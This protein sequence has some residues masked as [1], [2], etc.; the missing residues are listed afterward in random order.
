MDDEQETKYRVEL[1]F[2]SKDDNEANVA[3]NDAQ[4]EAPT[5]CSEEPTLRRSSREKR[6]PEYYGIRVNVA[7]QMP[8]EPLTVEDAFASSDWEK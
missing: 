6:L 7:D 5:D 1:D 2:K 8:K 4:E 3:N